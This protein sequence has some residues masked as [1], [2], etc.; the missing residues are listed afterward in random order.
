M[1]NESVNFK[2]L[3]PSLPPRHLKMTNKSAKLKSWSFVVFFMTLACEG[4]F[5]QI[6]HSTESRCGIGCGI[7]P[8]NT[9]SAGTAMN[10]SAQIFY[11]LG[12]EGV[13][14]GFVGL[15]HICTAPS[16]PPPPILSVSLTLCLSLFPPLPLSPLSLPPLSLSLPPSPSLSPLSLCL[17]LP[18]SLPLS[19]YQS[20]GRVC[21][22]K[23]SPR[24]STTQS[25]LLST[26][27]L[28]VMLMEMPGTGCPNNFGPFLAVFLSNAIVSL[29]PNITVTCLLRELGTKDQNTQLKTVI[30]V[31]I[32]ILPHPE[33]VIMHIVMKQ[34]KI[35]TYSS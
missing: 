5:T 27:G 16:S 29:S 31:I 10:L 11:M 9:L 21:W 6:T 2:L 30:T 22:D 13:E 8:E 28:R 34:Y 24:Q 17:P 32:S 33:K 4:I 12:R 3:T 15:S 20:A 14:T 1:T 35:Y 7:G 23:T 18:L 19:S 26:A 25:M